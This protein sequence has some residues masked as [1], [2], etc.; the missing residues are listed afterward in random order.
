MKK[1]YKKNQAVVHDGDMGCT[2]APEAG[3][4]GKQTGRNQKKSYSSVNLPIWKEKSAALQT[5][6]KVNVDNR[7]QDKTLV[8]TDYIFVQARRRVW[9]IC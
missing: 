5:N 1:N 7:G 8:C 9:C 6:P 4:S 3:G 2:M